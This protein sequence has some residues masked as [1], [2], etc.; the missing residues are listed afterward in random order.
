MQYSVSLQAEGDGFVA[1]C[2]ELGISSRGLSP[3]NALDA[4]RDSIRFNIEFCPC[5]TVDEGDIE[6][7]VH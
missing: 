7:N 4:L 6:L 5:S 3:A 2:A 1:E